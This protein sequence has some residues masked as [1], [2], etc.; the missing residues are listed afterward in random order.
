M[1]KTLTAARVPFLFET[2]VTTAAPVIFSCVPLTGLP[3]GDVKVKAAEPEATLPFR[4]GNRKPSI[5]SLSPVSGNT[6]VSANCQKLSEVLWNRRPLSVPCLS[7]ILWILSDAL[8]TYITR[9]L[10]TVPERLENVPLDVRED[11]GIVWEGR[12]ASV[13][14]RAADSRKNHRNRD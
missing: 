9:S 2:T 6:I 4:L 8:V 3:A 11:T 13:R 12:E 14:R 1:L 5:S 10:L 7:A